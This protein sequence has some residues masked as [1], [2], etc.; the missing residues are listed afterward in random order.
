MIKGVIDERLGK[1]HIQANIF[2]TMNSGNI[3]E[4]MLHADSWVT[5]SYVG[6]YVKLRPNTHTAQ[7]EKKLPAMVEKY[8]G[9][10][11]RNAGRQMQLYLQPVRSIHT[12]YG[13]RWVST[14]EAGKSFFSDNFI[15]H[16]NADP[17][18]G[19]Y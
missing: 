7:L 14:H 11:L 12:Y 3:G 6:S 18:R 1:S 5:N 19:L 13:A 10:E 16:C 2:I 4:Y 15:A 9:Q 17:T 8:G